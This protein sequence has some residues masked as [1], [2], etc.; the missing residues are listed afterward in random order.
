VNGGGGGD[1]LPGGTLD[2]LARDVLE[3]H[4]REP[5]FCVPHAVTYP[6]QWLWDS[7]FHA[8]VWAQLGRGDRAVAELAAALAAQAGDGFVPHVHYW[9][10]PVHAGFWGRPDTSCLTQ[11]PLYGHAV[12][13]LARRGVDV[14]GEVVQRA[15]AGL[16][17]LAARRP[18]GAIWHP[19][20]SGCDDSPRWDRWCRGGW[21]PER[22]YDVKGDLVASLV[23]D[24]DTASPVANPA[25]TVVPAG[26]AALC[27]FN[28]RELASVAAVAVPDAFE[29]LAVDL[30]R[31]FDPRLGTWPDVGPDDVVTSTTRTLD[32]LLPV[33]LE[34]SGS[35]VAAQVLDALVDDPGWAGP[36]GP[37]GVHR[38]EPSFAPD[39]YWR[40]PVWPQ[41]V[42]LLWVAACRHG[43][44]AA[45]RRLATGL[46]AGARRSGLAEFWHPDT[47]AG[48]GAVP[49]SWTT[50]AAVVAGGEPGGR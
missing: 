3:A 41:L 14:P 21:D 42:Y 33:L 7:C 11:P 10:D 48:L 25:F 1:T 24:P 39:T 20:E 36:F 12:A 17:H 32:A 29:H 34:P 37:P 40:G 22:W 13:E 38:G 47:G 35:L 16:L 19:W 5:G 28:A 27:V 50:L 15:A 2:D 45:A 18:V 46:A 26:F 23:R 6:W 8:V 49:Q 44:E 43:H 9:R 30:R 31:R 4:W